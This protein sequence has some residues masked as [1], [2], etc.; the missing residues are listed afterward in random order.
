MRRTHRAGTAIAL[1]LAVVVLAALLWPEGYAVNRA[2]VR[3]YAAG[4]RLGVPSSVTPE[5]YA[6][7]LNVLAFVPLGWLGVVALRGRPVVVVAALVGL[8]VAVELVQAL[9]GV[10]RDPSVGDVVLNG[11]GALAGAG[12][13]LLA[14]HRERE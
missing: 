12:L 11:L 5:D 3:V 6:L 13:G 10:A 2:I 1:A 4:L 7:L 14:R 9:P 8:S